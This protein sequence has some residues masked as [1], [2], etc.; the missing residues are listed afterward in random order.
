MAQLNSPGVSVSV[1]NESFYGSASQGTVPFI[2]IATAQ[3][4][5]DSANSAVAEGTKAK[6]AG[7]LY[8]ITSQRE[9]LMNFGNPKFY[10]VNGTSLHGYPLNEYGL[11][12]AHSYLGTSNR[13]FVMRADIDLAQLNPSSTPP[14]SKPK[15]GTFW[16]KKDTM[17]P[18]IYEFKS[19]KWVK[20][21]AFVATEYVITPSLNPPSI[22]DFSLV[23][24]PSNYDYAILSGRFAF[25]DVL[26]YLYSN[27]WIPAYD[28]IFASG[29][30]DYMDIQNVIVK[31]DGAGWKWFVGV[32]IGG[33]NEFD[34]NRY[35]FSDVY[36]S[37]R[38][39]GITPNA[40]GD[41]WIN[42]RENVYDIEKYNASTDSYTT[43]TYPINVSFNE[44]LAYYENLSRPNKGIQI[45]D[46]IAMTG[47][48]YPLC[49]IN[50]DYIGGLTFFQW[51][52]DVKQYG[53]IDIAPDF[54]IASPVNVDIFLLSDTNPEFVNIP[55]S[56]NLN[57]IIN[58]IN[59]YVSTNPP[60]VALKDY[61]VTCYYDSVARRV[62]F[63]STTNKIYG[64]KSEE[65]GFTSFPYTLTGVTGWEPIE[66]I[67]S[68]S[69]PTTS[70]VDGTYWYSED[71]KVDILKNDGNGNWVETTAAPSFAVHVYPEKPASPSNN[72]LWI[73][74]T[75]VA[76]YP[77]IQRYNSGTLSWELVDIT[78]QTTPDGIIFGDARVDPTSATL[79][80]DA[81]D[82]LMY[83]KDILLFNTRYSTRNVKQYVVNKFPENDEGDRDRWV[84]ISGLKPDGSPYMGA[85]AVY[86]VISVAMQAAIVANDAIRSED[87]YFNLVAAPGYPELI[88]ELVTLNDDRKETGF[89]IGDC[90]FNLKPTSDSVIAWAKNANN[91]ITNGRDGLLTANHNLAVYYPCGLTTNVDGTEVAVPPSHMML[92]TFAYN[93]QV[94]YQ[95]FAPAGL[96]RGV[97]S[98][99]T[100]VGYVSS[101]GEFVPVS[102]NEGIRDSLYLNNINPIRM[103]VN[104]GVIAWG[105]KTRSPASS[106][107][108]R[109]NV[110]RLV[111]YIRLQAPKIVEPF[112]FDQNDKVSRKSAKA[113]IDAMMSELVSLRGV[114]DWITV[115]DESN[116]TPSR[117]DRNELWIDIAVKPTKTIEFIYIPIRLKRT[118]DDLS[119]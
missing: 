72:D 63:D 42:T 35:Q 26:K 18:A 97:I 59:T 99:A 34:I 85:D 89:I 54:T 24:V 78:D 48:D 9:L 36:P 20:Q 44:G 69:Q 56:G 94:A 111:N 102:L 11:L 55:V 68:S 76:E 83:P 57:N 67:T 118:G 62:V 109:I 91:A 29:V 119:I 39:D 106:A 105:Q 64:I 27:I 103:M 80:P 93:D 4:K 38:R 2:L 12:A 13:A 100:S 41:V 53:T 52:G 74:T 90:P 23:G 110:A 16:L 22:N 3:D 104:R 65:L 87:I 98:N 6:N 40:E 5:M 77:V 45:G 19:G 61:G 31:R 7:K 58:I 33:G 96:Q 50:N 25:V 8:E 21:K 17:D 30:L 32:V 84:T 82:A 66:T 51:T 47:N 113:V 112:L 95:W 116:N 108:D 117:I 1:I 81:P 10:D 15:D 71:F 46:T 92:R 101:E 60:N 49:Q 115:C 79:D 107:L 114:Y 75:Q 86:R 14:K 37:K 70:G 73:D 28:E 43:V 88:D